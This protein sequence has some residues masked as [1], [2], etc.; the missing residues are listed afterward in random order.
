[1]QAAEAWWQ[2]VCVTSTQ[3]K[4]TCSLL[5]LLEMGSVCDKITVNLVRGSGVPL[6]NDRE[7]C[8]GCFEQPVESTTH[9]C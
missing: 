3:D 9:G 7:G 2:N 1:M 8:I 4:A 5:L 6:S